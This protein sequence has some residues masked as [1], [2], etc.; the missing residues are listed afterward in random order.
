[1][2]LTYCDKQARFRMRQARLDNARRRVIR[3]REREE[4]VGPAA[5]RHCGAQPCGHLWP[6]TKCCERCTHR[7]PEGWEHTH[8]ITS[9][10][11]Q[12]LVMGVWVSDA[13][14]LFIRG[15]GVIQWVE[16]VNEEGRSEVS[17][18]AGSNAHMPALYSADVDPKAPETESEWG[19][20][21][22][23]DLCT[24]QLEEEEEDDEEEDEE[25]E[26]D[27]EEDE[28]F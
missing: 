26:E 20:Y 7:A 17:F 12:F 4:E 11:H 28:E 3:E 13:V 15:D 16:L 10:G 24:V 9:D 19:R 23:L 6:V 8:T 14:R 22:P 18:L 2:A 21:L 27:P 1:M 25:L 5:C